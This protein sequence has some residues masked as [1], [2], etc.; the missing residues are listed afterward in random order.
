MTLEITASQFH[1]GDT[2][3]GPT[4]VVL[5]DG[6]VV[7]VEPFGG[8]TDH[9]LVAP[10]LVDLQMNGFGSVDVSN[11]SHEDFL[12]L[13]RE[14]LAGGTTSWLATI[15]TAP[16]DRL[17]RS[18][19]RLDSWITRGDTGCLGI[20]V[21]GPF[22]GG[23]P[24]A[25]NPKW[26]I[27]YDIDWLTG[28]PETVRLVTLAPEQSGTP[29]VVS[30][31]R[32]RGVTVSLGHTRAGHQDFD[33]AVRA[34]A[35]MV[36]HLFNGMSGVHHRD[37]GVA[38]S[39]LT[40][41]RVV[42]GM[43]ADGVHVSPRAMALAYAA[44]TAR[45]VCLVSDSIAW[46]SEWATKMNVVLRDGAP[47]LPDGTIAGSSA[48]LASCVRNVVA[49]SGVSREDAIASATST[50]SDLVGFPQTGRVKPGQQSELICFDDDLHV[51]EVHRR[52]VSL[53]GSQTD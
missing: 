3:H 39:A 12:R 32:S 13:D 9:A 1:D 21:E 35:T 27:E 33:A 40:D 49:R 44:K 48:T 43:I 5:D 26:I 15:V 24:G 47:R 31:L 7:C 42:A 37:D 36:T 34:G 4:L 25:H 10:G 38:L 29:E 53:R 50:P 22:L 51:V 19:E 20:H 41:V 30:L 8:S 28:L 17:A 45:G 18:I 23:A 46:K 16:L 52:L 6:F 14:L 2:L 11:C